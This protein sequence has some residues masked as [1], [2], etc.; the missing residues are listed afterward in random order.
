MI[1]IVDFSLKLSNYTSLKRFIC[2]ESYNISPKYYILSSTTTHCRSFPLTTKY[3]SRQPHR[4]SLHVHIRMENSSIW[5]DC[6]SII[7]ISH[8][9]IHFKIKPY[10][11]SKIIYLFVEISFYN[12]VYIHIETKF[13]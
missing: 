13:I 8:K 6:K 9:E 11:F 5:I 12:K 1:L 10:I 7:Y 3:F 4:N 2:L